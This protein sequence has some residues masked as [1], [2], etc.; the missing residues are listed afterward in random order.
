MK[1]GTI[2]AAEVVERLAEALVSLPRVDALLY[3]STVREGRV[4]GDV[5]VWLAGDEHAVELAECALVRLTLDLPF[6][7]DV[8][9]P[10]TVRAGSLVDEAICWCV[11]EEGVVLAGERPTSPAG[12]TFER[13]EGAFRT[14]T[15]TAAADLGHRADVLARAGDAAAALFTEA[16]VRTWVQS[17]ARDHEEERRVRRMPTRAHLVRLRLLSPEIHDVLLQG[18]W[19]SPVLAERLADALRRSA[20]SQR[21]PDSPPP[22]SRRDAAFEGAPRSAHAETCSVRR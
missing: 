1:R 2:G 4:V 9:R 7:I 17:Q 15:I 21:R 18:D 6:R 3:G 5:D 22:P 20:D 14:A 12:M 19:S 16:A 11:H 10:R 13:A 8:T